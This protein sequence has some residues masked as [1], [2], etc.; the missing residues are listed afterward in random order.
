MANGIFGVGRPLGPVAPGLSGALNPL[1]FLGS[2]MAAGNIGGSMAQMANIQQNAQQLSLQRQQMAQDALAQRAANIVAQQRLAHQMSKPTGTSLEQNLAAAG[3]VPGTPEYQQ[4][5]MD[6]L[7]KSG[8][9]IQV[10]GPGEFGTVPPAMARVTDPTSPTGSRLVEEPGAP[11]AARREAEKRKQLA[12][13]E[14]MEYAVGAYETLLRQ[15]GPEIL[16]GKAKDMLQGAY[17]AL[18]IEAKELA[19]LGAL[20]G[21]D[22]KLVEDMLADPTTISA[23]AKGVD[24]LLAQLNVVKARVAAA[25]KRITGKEPGAAPLPPGFVEE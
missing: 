24:S 19:K 18:V 17:K 20:T 15:H 16:P 22:L 11:A 8:T 5:V 25:R 14:S 23:Q 1:M 12:P 3:L 9:T 4:A 13:V 21:D 6:Y 10:G 2:G 7:Q